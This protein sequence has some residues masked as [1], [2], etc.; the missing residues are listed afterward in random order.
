MAN[1]NASEAAQ[2]AS[3]CGVLFL[4][5]EQ[6][7]PST[8]YYVIPTIKLYGLHVV[9]CGFNDL[10]SSAD[11]ADSVVIFVRYVPAQWA[12]LVEAVRPSLRALI[13]F[14]DDDVLDVTASVGTPWKYRFK[15][16]RLAA[17][18]SGWLRQQGAMLWVST[19]YLQVKYREWNPLLVLPSPVETPSG[20]CRVFYH[21]SASHSEEIRWL[22]PVMEEALRREERLVLE[23]VGGR[24]VYYL[25]RNLPRVNIMHPMK[26]GAYQYFLSMQGRHIGLA[27]LLD[28]PFN[29]AR[30][31][32]KFFDFTRCGAVGIYS[33]IGGNAEIITHGVDG[34]VVKLNQEAWV[35]AIL[36]LASNEVMRASMLQNAALTSTQLAKIAQL[37]Y[38]TLLQQ[39]G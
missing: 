14:M 34:L 17:W 12:R 30:S 38:S 25:Y 21:G 13:F 6:P 4:V 15:L 8:D 28:L 5:E 22:R 36:E 24:D 10:P 16:A 9:R 20:V 23:I 2:M 11:M 27:P 32:T 35:G 39:N 1:L 31:Y 18:R 3:A 29:H 7:N 19:S 26:W 37:G 33:P